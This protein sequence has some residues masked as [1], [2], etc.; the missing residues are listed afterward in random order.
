MSHRAERGDAVLASGKQVRC[1][2]YAG[3]VA[4]PRDLERRV[5]AVCAPRSEIHHHSSASDFHHTSCLARDDALQVNLVHHEGLGELGFQDRGDHLNDRLV[6]KDDSPFRHRPDV[7][8]EANCRERLQEFLGKE[9]QFAQ[10][11]NVLWMEL[12]R[13]EEVED[14]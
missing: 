2:R 12:K 10:V 4:G 14:I 9:P 13:F 11:V 5:G 7:S 6:W 8:G 1:A 3:Q